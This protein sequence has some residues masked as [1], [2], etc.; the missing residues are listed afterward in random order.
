[1]DVLAKV[2][3]VL[4]K[5]S[6]WRIALVSTIATFLISLLNYL[7]G[8]EISISIFYLIPIAISTWYCGH[9]AGIIFSI[10]SAGI[11]FVA[12]VMSNIYSNPFAPYMNGLFRL[13]LFLV[14]EGLINRTK[15]F[16]DIE[17]SL[18]RI[19]S[20]TG[21][22]N[23][24]GFAEQVEV[25][26]DLAARHGRPLVLAYI[27]LDNFKKVNDDL[28]HSEGNIVLQVVGQLITASLRTTDVA[29]RLGGDEFAIVLPETDEG[30]AQIVVAT[31][32]TALLQAVKKH[33]WPI[34]LSIGVI[35][36]DSPALSLDEALRIA[37]SL[38]YQAKKRG[39]N[40]II[41]E[42]YPR[43]LDSH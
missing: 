36:F 19:D 24:R 9:R 34:T 27:D 42:H 30:G 21:L 3:S 40:N 15:I 32:S 13:S 41:F 20:L 31:L 28:G 11:W 22:L 5:S 37:D 6:C 10:L 35:S 43:I 2:D 4:N 1:M 12:D 25:L 8:Q 33:G 14:T 38:M 39:K 23:F 7:S 26:F 29:G 18:S 16:V 17:K